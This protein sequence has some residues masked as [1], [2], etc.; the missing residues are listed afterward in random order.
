MNK[1]ELRS[2]IEHLRL[3]HFRLLVLLVEHGTVRQ[4][5]KMINVSQPVASQMLA[6]AEFAFGGTL[7]TRT[8]G[9]VK[10]TPR[11]EVLLRRV[12]FILGELEVANRE[13]ATP[14]QV[15]I[16]IGASLQFLTQLLPS[17]LARLHSSNPEIHFLVREG[18]GDSLIQEVIQGKLDCAIA[19]LS[20]LTLRDSKNDSDLQFWPLYGGKLCLVVN[21][22]HPLS[23]RKRVN[24]HDLANEQWALGISEGQGREIIDRVF[25]DAGLR[26]PRPVIECRPQYANLAFIAKLP[27]VA[28]AT[29]AD[30]IAGQQAGLLHILP[31]DISQKIAPVAFVCR[32]STANDNWLMLLRGAVTM[33]AQAPVNLSSS[34]SGWR[35]NS[36]RHEQKIARHARAC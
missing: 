3:K 27:L 29:H 23:K 34:Q 7:F 25:I 16:R 33:A 15:S 26:P 18:S 36:R 13:L 30:A 35:E 19:R 2:T 8:R 31:I 28:V 1:K 6:E 9:G 24:I 4:A 10:A 11:L 20:T 17:A 21:K 5:A 22:S 32:K 14:G 12:R